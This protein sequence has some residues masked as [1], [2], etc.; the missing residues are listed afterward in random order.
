MAYKS[1]SPQVRLAKLRAARPRCFA[2]PRGTLLQ[3]NPMAELLGVNWATLRKWCNGLPGFE[4]SGAFG[5]GGN[6]IDYEFCPVRTVVFLTEHFEGLAAEQVEKNRGLQRSVG[7]ELPHSE[8]AASVE[9]TRGLVNLT[10][11][12]VAA[13]KEQG[14]YTPTTEVIAFLET[15]NQRVV[16]GIMGVRTKVDPN[17]ALPPQVRFAIDD[18]LRGVATEAHAEASAAIGDYRAGIQQRGTGAAG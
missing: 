10:L 13:A 17:G 12:V 15:Y 2:K 3:A 6:G 14:L 7:V 5:R 18:Y 4:D 11:A 9:E 16:N 8:Q 1:A